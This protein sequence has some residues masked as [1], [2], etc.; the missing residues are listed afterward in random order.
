MN[1][2]LLCP[3]PSTASLARATTLIR[4]STQPI[5]SLNVYRPVPQRRSA[6]RVAS[7]QWTGQHYGWPNHNDDT[8][9]VHHLEITCRTVSVSSGRDVHPGTATSIDHCEQVFKS[10]SG[11]VPPTKSQFKFSAQC[12]YAEP[13]TGSE[14]ELHWQLELR[15]SQCRT[16][17]SGLEHGLG[18]KLLGTTCTV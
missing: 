6:T 4:S 3:S 5:T 16:V 2:S 12:V 8:H 7:T 18:T 15:Q 14:V 17:A 11:Q 9:H 10:T 1:A 13:A